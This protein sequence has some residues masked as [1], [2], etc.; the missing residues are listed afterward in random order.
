[1]H[2][3]GLHTTT[4]EQGKNIFKI[5]MQGEFNKGIV[6][7]SYGPDLEKITE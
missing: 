2:C 3:H 6:I 5:T 1:M 4:N 7:K